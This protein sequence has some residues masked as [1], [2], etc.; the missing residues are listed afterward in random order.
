MRLPATLDA[1]TS[2]NAMTHADD[3]PSLNVDVDPSWIDSYGH[4]NTA[5]YVYV[6]DHFGYVLFKHYGI[7]EE[8]TREKR[9]GLYN[10]EIRTCYL[11]ELLSGEALKLRLRVLNSDDKRMIVLYELFRVRDD[12]LAATMEQLS[13]HV[14]LNTR[15]VS[16][17]PDAVRET[18]ANAVAAHSQLP[19]P[20]GFSPLLS[21][22]PAAKR[23]SGGVA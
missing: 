20:A 6:F 8:Y 22:V 21:M 13:I 2:S 12:V 3:L 15:K 7:G 4:M 1:M 5:K 10:L 18:L 9:C 14:D 16:K 19:L 17:F 11:R 23:S